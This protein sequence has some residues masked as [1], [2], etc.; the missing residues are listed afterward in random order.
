MSE[1][2]LSND[3]NVITAEINSYKQV[4]GQAIFEIGRRLKHVK[5]NDLVHGEWKLFLESIDMSKSQADRFIK[6]FKEYD[7]G[8]LP[9]VG[10]IGLSVLYE[11]STLPP[12]ERGKEHTLSSGEAKTVDEMTVRELQEVK[13]ALKQ[14]EQEKCRLA[15]RLTEE[16]NKQPEVIEKEIV[17]EVVPEHI[18]ME[19]DSTK[20]QLAYTTKQLKELERYKENHELRKGEFD[21]EEA[22]RERKK[23]MWEAD[24]NVLTLKIKVDKFLEEVAITA[25]MEGAIATAGKSTKEKLTE[26]VEMLKSFTSKMD[27]A[28][29]GRIEI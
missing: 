18:K 12:E 21:E 9:D 19:L 17:K 8:K 29:R 20:R 7:L 14:A 5:E 6:V 11:I 26:S 16:R 15:E 3:L 25:F 13:K 2:E 22:E 27:T 23:M 4:A 1:L 28:L 10:N 24:K